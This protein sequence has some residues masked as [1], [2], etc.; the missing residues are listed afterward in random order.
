VRLQ[1]CHICP[2]LEEHQALALELYWNC[3]QESEFLWLGGW[4]ALIGWLQMLVMPGGILLI[5]L[6]YE[7][8]VLRFS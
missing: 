4:D 8:L 6:L 3:F 2:L 7:S 5:W 1:G